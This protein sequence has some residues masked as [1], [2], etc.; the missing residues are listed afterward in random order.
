MS[1]I[2]MPG[3]VSGAPSGRASAPSKN[4]FV[5][6]PRSGSPAQIVINHVRGH[7]KALGLRAADV[8]DIAV[9]D[10]YTDA[11]NGVT[12]VYLRQRYNGIEVFDANVNVNV[13]RDGSI[14]SLDSSFVRDLAAKVKGKAHLSCRSDIDPG[15]RAGEL[16]TQGTESAQG[17]SVH[18]RSRS[19]DHLRQERHQ[20]EPVIPTKLVY[21]QVK[22]GNL[23]LARQI[24]LYELDGEHWWNLRVDATTGA[25]LARS[26]TSATRTMPTTSSRSRPRTLMMARGRWS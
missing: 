20:P 5:S 24:E 9:T 8:A 14:I 1:L 12:H 2:A 13:A 18:R 25:I 16:G 6:G 3:A 17:Q 23:R 22:G 11:H 26:T 7:A 4:S 15:R 21:Q 19:R 10:S